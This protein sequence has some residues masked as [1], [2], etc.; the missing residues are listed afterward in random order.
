MRDADLDEF[1]ALLDAT[2]SLLSR[3]NYTP[4]ATNTAL[5]FR[6]LREHSLDAVRGGLDAHVRDPQR[7]RFVPTPADVIAQIEGTATA[8]GRP[9]PEEAWAIALGSRDEADTVVWTRETAE[10]MGIATPLLEIRDEVGARMAFRESYNR[11]VDEARREHMPVSWVVS[12][13]FDSKRRDE[14][15]RAAVDSGR[16]PH[17]ALPA[18]EAGARVPLLTL[19]DSPRVPPHIREQLK[20]LSDSLRAKQDKPGADAI[21][22]AETD[23]KKAEATRLAEEYAREHG[24]DLH[25]PQ[26]AQQPDQQVIP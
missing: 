8:D 11:L 10:A 6:A 2:C 12:L 16:L 24:I 5:W 4:N 14:A 18:P 3:G 23:A 21:A 7:G 15:V 1:S 19:A 17:S 9:G 13:G 20:A 22:R 25:P 26:A